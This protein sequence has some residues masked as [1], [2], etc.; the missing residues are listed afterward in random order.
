MLLA[1][2]RPFVDCT[3]VTKGPK[4][5]VDS[6]QNCL[7]PAGAPYQR[8]WCSLA[9]FI[10]EVSVSRSVVPDSL[11]PHG[12]QPSVHEIFQARILEWVATSFSRGSSQ[13][14]NRTQVSCTAGR[15]FTNWA[16][17]EACVSIPVSQFLS[18]I[19][20]PLGIHIFVLSVCVSAL[21]IRSSIPFFF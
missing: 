13:P 21:Q 4:V 12:L 1:Y 19:P 15:F 16:T 7:F 9:V 10:P 2:Q 20:Y 5:A 6:A 17:R 11:R 14:R 3:A 8:H 18:P